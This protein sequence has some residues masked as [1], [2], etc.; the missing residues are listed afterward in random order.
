MSTVASL[1]DAAFMADPYPVYADLRA[2]GPVHAIE[3]L[4]RTWAFTRHADVAALLKDPALSARR[5]SALVDQFPPE[6]RAEL[7][8]F[9]R[10]F[11]MWMLFFDPPEHTRAR[12][13]LA[14]AFAPDA[15]A[16][17]RERIDEAVTRL[18][19]AARDRGTGRFDVIADLAR[20]LPA[21]VIADWMAIPGDD[22]EAFV[23]WTDD[24]AEFFGSSQPTLPMARRAQDGLSALTDC[25]RRLVRERHGGAADDLVSELANGSEID[26]VADEEALA[27]QCAMLAFA[28][29]ETTRNLVGN[30]ALALLGDEGARAT[31]LSGAV[32]ARTAIDE[33]LRYDSPV[34]FGTRFAATDF[35]VHGVRV[36][37]GELIILLFGSA[38][39]DDAEFAQPDRLDLTRQPNRHVSFGNGPHTCIGAAL[40]HLEGA[41]ALTALFRRFPSLAV[42]GRDRQW[43]ANFGFRG[44]RE[45]PVR[46]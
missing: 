7:A 39:R 31:L 30:G 3:L 4:G 43:S 14:R 10:L 28:G 46:F 16:R 20:P 11:S 29:H 26:P 32:S 24:I 1:F 15:L 25:F 13:W 41:A 5:G 17:L 34:Q 18:L 35:D 23:G 9:T 12:R 22:R 8:T 38:N 27:A 2:A 21:T 36:Q 6:A 44:L 37:R 45:L 33:L 40:A 19:D 42:D